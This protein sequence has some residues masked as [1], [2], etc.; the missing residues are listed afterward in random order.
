MTLENGLLIYEKLDPKFWQFTRELERKAAGLLS[1]LL[2]DEYRPN[3]S[4]KCVVQ[5][6]LDEVET[7]KAGCD[8]EKKGLYAIQNSPSDVWNAFQ[9]A[10]RARRDLDAL[11]P[12]M[13]L[14]GFGRTSGTAKRATAVLRIF[15]PHEWG[16]VDW[17]VAAML[18]ELELR[19]WNVDDVI[20]QPP[21]DTQPWDT[22]IEINDSLAVDLN[23]IYRSKRSGFLPRTADVE[24]A[25][26][27]LSF[28]VEGWN[29]A[30]QFL[31]FRAAQ[32]GYRV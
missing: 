25:I 9:S 24:M 1:P 2:N 21:H 18:K 12:I 3:D 22:Y 27:G 30:Q 8:D 26:F 17:R 14:T 15:K 6:L 28:K 13:T 10:V 31:N 29:R 23:E 19:N 20:K 32:G 5:N 7:W 16:V 11:R 4:D